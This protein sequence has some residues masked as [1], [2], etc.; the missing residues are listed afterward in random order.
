M[1]NTRVLY[2]SSIFDAI[3]YQKLRYGKRSSCIGELSLMLDV[4]KELKDIS[5]DTLPQG[6]SCLQV[7]V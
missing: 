7:Q 6:Q 4:C 2:F 1:N 3:E 5:G